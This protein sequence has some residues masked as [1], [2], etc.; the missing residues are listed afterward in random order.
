MS[1]VKQDTNLP[2]RKAVGGVDFNAR[3]VMQ[4]RLPGE[5]PAE[6]K[7]GARVKLANVPPAGVYLPN[8]NRLTPAMRSGGWMIAAANLASIASS[9]TSTIAF[10]PPSMSSSAVPEIGFP[11]FISHNLLRLCRM[12][13]RSES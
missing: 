13:A 11:G 3:D 10:A 9:T 12:L 4:P 1:C 5:I 2:G 7:N 6:A 8:N